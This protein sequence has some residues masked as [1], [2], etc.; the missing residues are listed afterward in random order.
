MVEKNKLSRRDFIKEAAA[1]A[2][3]V[4]G[5]GALSGLGT[6]SV[7]AQTTCQPWMPAKW[8]YEA[9]VVIVGFGGAGGVTAIT[10]FDQGAKVLILEKC[11]KDTPT[12]VR[13]TPASKASG[14]VVL[15]ASDANLAAQHI[16]EI[17]RGTTPMDVCQAYAEGAVKVY[18]YIKDF[19]KVEVSKLNDNMSEYKHTIGHEKIQQFNIAPSH[20][21]PKEVPINERGAYGTGSYLFKAIEDNVNARKIPVLWETRAKELIQDAV[22]GEILGVKAEQGG[23]EITVKARRGVAMTTGGFEYNEDLLK[24]HMRTYPWKWYGTPTATGDGIL[25]G[26]KVGAALWHMNTASGRAVPWH[27]GFGPV[28]GT[29]GTTLP[30]ILVNNYG[31]RW[32]KWPWPSHGGWLEF[33]Y[34]DAQ[35]E[36][37]PA[38]PAWVIA[39]EST[40]LKGPLI[41]PRGKGILNEFVPG[42]N[43]YKT[44][45]WFSWSADNL[46]EIEKGWILKGDTIEALAEKIK[47][48]PENK[49]ALHPEGRMDPAVLK[50]TVTNYNQFCATGKDLEFGSTV[51]SPLLKPPFY[52]WKM[53]PGGPLTHGGLKRDAQSRV[54]DAFGKPIPRLYGGGENGS[55]FGFLYPVGGAAICEYCTFGQIAGKNLAAEKPWDAKA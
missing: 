1:G 32:F 44:Q 16:F 30:C 46:P 13:H 21:S 15:A 47:A 52:A 26:Q 45:A 14:G 41:T 55:I 20:S 48:D 2:A 43:H 3:A 23:K 11:P 31:R 34:Y 24:Y 10:A 12:E 25:M 6:T 40:R 42:T 51:L 17:S 53:Y 36:D 19:I 8:D 39:D 54:L 7:S 35:G 18:S 50:A 29:G 33:C 38:N 9:D 49:S 5:A 28:A 4:A 27:P 37:Y 22:T